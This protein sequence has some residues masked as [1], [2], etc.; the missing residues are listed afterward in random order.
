MLIID[1]IVKC[2]PYLRKNGRVV[3]THCVISTVHSLNHNPG[4]TL[5]LLERAELSVNNLR[6]ILSECREM[7][8]CNQ[9]A[10]VESLQP[11]FGIAL[12]PNPPHSPLRRDSTRTK[13]RHDLPKINRQNPAG[14]L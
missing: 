4:R 6:D 12:G 3:R 13:S 5:T 8:T 7:L 2:A 9:L 14:W 11:L 1:D 10:P